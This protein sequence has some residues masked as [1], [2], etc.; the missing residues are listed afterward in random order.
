VPI[1]GESGAATVA[2][3]AVALG[4]RMRAL[5]LAA[6]LSTTLLPAT[7]A[8]AA[9]LSPVLAGIQWGEGA[10]ELAHHFGGRAIRLSPPIEFGDSYVDVALRNQALGGFAFTV[11]FQM[12][13]RTRG[14]KRVMF[15]RQRHGANP[16]VFR[17]VLEALD[18]DYGPPARSCDMPA[19]SERI[20]HDHDDIIRAVFLIGHLYLQIG[21][22]GRGADSCLEAAPRT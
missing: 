11:Y 20:W 6:F 4:R 5:V 17:A 15:E 13:K 12:D 14:L 22:V 8:S 21:P 10:D 7:G 1:G 2:P 19:A 3:P 9:A 16:R 18:A